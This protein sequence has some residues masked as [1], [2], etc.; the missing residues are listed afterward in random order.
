MAKD[1]IRIGLIGA[2]GNTRSRHIPGLK[3]QK[4]VEIVTVANRTPESAKKVADEFGIPKVADDWQAVLADDSVDAVCIGTWPY[5]HAPLSIAALKAGKCPA[6]I[7]P[8]ARSMMAYGSATLMP[9]MAALEGADWKLKGL[10]KRAWAKLAADAAAE[11]REVTAAQLG[12]KPPAMMGFL[13]AP[14]I[15]LATVLAPGMLPFEVEIYLRYHFTKVR[16]Q[17]RILL[18]RYIDEG[19][20]R[21]VSIT[22]LSVLRSRVFGLGVGGRAPQAA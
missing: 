13:G 7:H 11:A 12:S 10:R 6:K 21:G 1:V 15:Q 19:I 18:D 2:G 16:D 5:M 4:G 22:N 17:T 20:D 9:L 3:E 14:V 8:D